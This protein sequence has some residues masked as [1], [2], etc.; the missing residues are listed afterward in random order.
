MHALWKS[1]MGVTMPHMNKQWEHTHVWV[2]YQHCQTGNPRVNL[3]L[4]DICH[5][6]SCLGCQKIEVLETE[7]CFLIDERLGMFLFPFHTL[8]FIHISNVGERMPWLDFR[9]VKKKESLEPPQA[10][11]QVLTAKPQESKFTKV[12]LMTFQWDK[13]AGAGW[14]VDINSGSWFLC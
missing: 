4:L 6:C 11:H 14:L 10:E 13:A 1:T 12:V 8:T 2:L 9:F 3:W 5:T 7:A